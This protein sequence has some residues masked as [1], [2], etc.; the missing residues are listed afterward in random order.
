MSLAE[1]GLRSGVDVVVLVYSLATLP[2]E[3][4]TEPPLLTEDAR[5]DALSRLARRPGLAWGLTSSG[6]L[7]DQVAGARRR[8]PT[9]HLTVLLG[10]DKALQLLDPRWYADRDAALDRLLAEADVRFAARS[11]E[12]LVTPLLARRGYERWAGRFTRLRAAA[13][14]A[15]TS[16]GEVR[17][18][19]RRGEDVTALVPPEVLPLPATE[20]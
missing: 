20:P 10:S 6:L 12:D 19:H 1:A 15:A 3:A 13:E 18:R 2:K 7:V 14:A 5:L 4:G 9:A 8:W 17:R 16:S 11:G